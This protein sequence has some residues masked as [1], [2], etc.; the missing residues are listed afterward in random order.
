[1]TSYFDTS[2]LAKLYIPEH[3]S[4][5]ICAFV[6]ER[7]LSIAINSFQRAELTNA[8]ALKVFRQEISEAELNKLL[9]K[10]DRD[11]SRNHLIMASID[12]LELWEV[13]LELS[14]QYTQAFGCRTLDI[15]HVAAAKIMNCADFYTNDRRQKNLAEAV[16]IETYLYPALPPVT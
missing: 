3:D 9:G 7:G 5:A 11:I 15:M 2:I 8:F 6:Q 12:W 10:V 1:M 16:E 14:C 4:E 13:S